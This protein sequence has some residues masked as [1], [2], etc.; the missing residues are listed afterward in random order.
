VWG[1]DDFPFYFVQL[2]PYA[3]GENPDLLPALWEAQTASLSIPNTG[4][5]VALDIGNVNNVHPQNKQD[6]GKRLALWALARTYGREDLVYSGPLYRSMRVNGHKAVVE[7]DHVGGGLISRDGKP[8]SHFRIAG[9]DRV[10][11]EAKAVIETNRVVV[12]SDAVLRPAAVRF[13][14]DQKAQPNLMNKESLPAA[15]FRTD[16]W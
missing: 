12:G 7:F 4:M 13:A 1:R 15:P 14:W 6:V 9:E 5:A 11:V 10:F 8:L 3:Y 2:A 16:T